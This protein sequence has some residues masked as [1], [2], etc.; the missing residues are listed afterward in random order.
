MGRP[1]NTL[2][3][4]KF[5]VRRSKTSGSWVILNPNELS[6]TV[7]TTTTVRVYPPDARG[8]ALA[9]RQAHVEAAHYAKTKQRKFKADRRPVVIWQGKSRG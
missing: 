9:I 1:S 2:T 7:R 5:M 8:F 6:P 3:I 4:R